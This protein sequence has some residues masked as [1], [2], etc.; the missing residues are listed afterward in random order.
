[1][2]LC[3]MIKDM[4]LLQSLKK[5]QQS[6]IEVEIV[7]KNNYI[8]AIHEEINSLKNAKDDNLNQKKM[9]IKSF[10]SNLKNCSKFN[11]NSLLEL[12]LEAAKYVIK[13]QEL[14]GHIESKIEALRRAEQQRYEL[15]VQ[16]KQVIV[17]LEK[18]NFILDSIAI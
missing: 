14:E 13:D 4:L 5:K 8:T 15:H 1:M 9:Y 7:K 16:L 3:I 18:Y 17:K 2:E 6:R 11:S 12:E 10:Y